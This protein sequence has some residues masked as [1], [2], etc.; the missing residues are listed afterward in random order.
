MCSV[1]DVF[2]KI[3][4]C[5]VIR[6]NRFSEPLLVPVSLDNRR[7]VVMWFYFTMP[8]YLYFFRNLSNLYIIIFVIKSPYIV[9]PTIYCKSRFE[10]ILLNYQ[11]YMFQNLGVSFYR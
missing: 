10:I 1:Y 9:M 11:K 8:H 4:F 2:C 6:K 3:A 7:F 5:S